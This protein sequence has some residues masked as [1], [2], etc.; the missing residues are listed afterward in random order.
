MKKEIFEYIVLLMLF[1]LYIGFAQDKQFN[2]NDLDSLLLKGNFSA[3]LTSWEKLSKTT[4]IL[5][6]SQ[7]DAV[8]YNRLS[9]NLHQLSSVNKDSLR[10]GCKIIKESY[11]I[12]NAERRGEK[13]NLERQKFLEAIVNQQH[14]EAWEYYYA[15]IYFSNKF[16]Q[17]EKI[18]LLKNYITAQEYLINGR[19]DDALGMIKTY[20]KEEPS[21]PAFIVLRDSLNSLYSELKKNTSNTKARIELE[22]EYNGVVKQFTISADIDYIA[23]QETDDPR[24]SFQHRTFSDLYLYFGHFSKETHGLYKIQAEYCVNSSVSFGARMAIGTTHDFTLNKATF[25]GETESTSYTQKLYSFGIMGKYFLG[26]IYIARPYL[27]VETGVI[28]VKRDKVELS[29]SDFLYPEYYSLIN[30]VNEIYPQITVELGAEINFGKKELFF[31]GFHLFL[32]NNFGDN[33]V[34][35]HINNGGGI[36]V[37]V[38]IF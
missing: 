36:R 19:F 16:I 21:N 22:T 6:I 12:F 33:R 17:L 26:N 32:S 15:T 28:S 8:G 4:E 14:F 18:R 1:L 11:L 2:G 31:I 9:K 29:P 35:Q 34:V 38:N 10:E 20:E 13:S 3:F 37:G 23:Y 27:C 7:E 25:L 30:G 24:M 5:D